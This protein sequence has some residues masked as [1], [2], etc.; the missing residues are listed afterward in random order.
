MKNKSDKEKQIARICAKLQLKLIYK[1]K[2]RPIDRKRW[3]LAISE[4]KY[5]RDR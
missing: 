1:G 2:W 5:V 4:L 3:E